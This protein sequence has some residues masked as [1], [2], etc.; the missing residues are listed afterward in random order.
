MDWRRWS[1]GVDFDRLGPEG[2]LGPPWLWAVAGVLLVLFGHKLYTALVGL[3]GF[4]VVWT[5]AP[6]LLPLPSELRLAVAVGAGVL[7]ALLGFIVR[8]L[9][10]TLTG[11]ILGAG[12]AVWLIVSFGAERDILWW[13]VVAT[14]AVLGAFLLR[15]VSELALVVASSLVGALLVVGALL[16]MGVTGLEGPPA[17]LGVALLLVVGIGVQMGLGR[18]KDRKRRRT[19]E[20]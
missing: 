17:W 13:V 8:T 18:G 12:L 11:A 1:E 9:A 20:Q 15:W 14:A 10:V 19:A 3:L 4:V 7:S 5:L 2:A 6:D 16:E